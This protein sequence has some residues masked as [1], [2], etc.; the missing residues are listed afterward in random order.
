MKS[1]AELREL[2]ARLVRALAYAKSL[3]LSMHQVKELIGLKVQIEWIL[4]DKSAA[5]STWEA[6]VFKALNNLEGLK[7]T[8]ERSVAAGNN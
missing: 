2:H 8:H 1:E 7:R 5:A 6:A 4:G 3:R